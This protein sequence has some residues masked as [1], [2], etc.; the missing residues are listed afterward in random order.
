[1]EEELISVI[2]AGHFAQLL[3]R[4]GS[5]GMGCDIAVDPATSL[6]LDDDEYVE[7]A[8][9]RCD[10]EAEAAGENSLSVK[11]QEGRPAQIPSRPAR[12]T[13]GHVLAHRAWRDPDA[14]LQQQ[15]I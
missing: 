7:H 10:G 13:P 5:S 1:M 9:V 2:D 11:T 3:Q 8:K 6:V 15:L 4:P 14:E 12:R